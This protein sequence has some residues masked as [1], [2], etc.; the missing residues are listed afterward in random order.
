[1]PDRINKDS[2]EPAYAQLAAILR[3]QIAGGVYPPGG[4][5]PPESSISRQYGLSIMTVRQAIGVLTEQGLIERIQGSGTFVKPVTLAGSRFDLDSIKEIFQA[6][7]RTRVKVLRISL[8]RTDEKTAQKLGLSAGARV[9][10]IRRILLRDNE[11]VMSH[12]GRIRCDPNRPVVEAELNIGPLSDL[13]NGHGGGL[14]KKGELTVLPTVLDHEEARLLNQ[15]AG[16][17]VFRLEYLVYD[18]HDTPFGW[19]WF[20]AAPGTLTLKAKLGLWDQS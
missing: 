8:V 5:I 19:G 10:L 7:E 15:P 2:F 4:R 14:A 9:I 17:P 11:A 3:R 12:E 6:S 20:T 18:F 16:T 13:F 1:M